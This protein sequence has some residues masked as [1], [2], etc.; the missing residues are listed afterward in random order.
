MLSDSVSLEPSVTL[1]REE[2]LP[3][4]LGSWFCVTFTLLLLWAME[5]WPE[6]FFAVEM[7]IASMLLN[8]QLHQMMGTRS[9]L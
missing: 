2:V 8:R 9:V 3:P 1:D 6:C 5:K 4:K 7:F